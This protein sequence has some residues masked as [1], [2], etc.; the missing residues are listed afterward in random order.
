M[1][2]Q[3]VVM[4]E[5]FLFENNRFTFKQEMMFETKNISQ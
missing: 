3:N 2:Q 4:F 1:K 5:E